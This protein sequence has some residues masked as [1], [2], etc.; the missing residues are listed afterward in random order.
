[1]HE[2]VVKNILV[3]TFMNPSNTPKPQLCMHLH[4]S[5]KAGSLYT[6]IQLYSRRVELTK[7]VMKHILIHVTEIEG[8]SVAY[9]DCIAAFEAPYC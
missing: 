2:V 9:F 6:Q 8:S 1:M 7:F 3:I 4:S 5:M